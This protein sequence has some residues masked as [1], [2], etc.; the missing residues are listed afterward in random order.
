[1]W[2]KE[3][4]KMQVLVYFC[5][6]FWGFLCNFFC[7]TD[8]LYAVVMYFITSSLSNLAVYARLPKG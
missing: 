7:L 5:N 8:L 3:G 4:L 6:T 1:M 2:Q